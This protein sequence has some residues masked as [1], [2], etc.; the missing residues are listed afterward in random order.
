M[1]LYDH[2]RALP[3]AVDEYRLEGLV[4]EVSSGFTRKTTVV[5]VGPWASTSATFS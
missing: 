3:L 4:Q 5:R 1:S 2:V